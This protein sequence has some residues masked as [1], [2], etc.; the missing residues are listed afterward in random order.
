MTTFLL[1]CF[2]T[3]FLHVGAPLVSLWN[4]D[5]I[6]GGGDGQWKIAEGDERCGLSAS[7]S[8]A[9]SAAVVLLSKISM[10]SI[11]LQ[12]MERESPALW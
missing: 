8:L 11:I 5:P 2:A 3:L 10:I 12:N 7:R 1:I 4:L 9:Y 6:G